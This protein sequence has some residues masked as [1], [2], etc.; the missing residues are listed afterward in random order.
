MLIQEIIKKKRDGGALTPQEITFAVRG[1]ASGGI[2]DYQISA[3]LMA[4]LLRGMQT[5][6]ITAMVEAMTHSGEVVDLSAIPGVK[7]DKHSTGGIGDKV[8]LVLAPLVAALGVKVPMIS[9]RGL[10]HTGGTLDKLE[11]IPGF[12][13]R[14]DLA[15]FKKTVHEVGA[16]LIGQTDNLAPADRKLYALRDVTGTVESPALIASSIL[17]KKF[18][19]GIDGLVMDVKVGSGAFMKNAADAEALAR[20]LISIGK[21]AG[22]P[23]VAVLTDM[24][25]PLGEAVGNALEVEESIAALKGGGPADLRAVTLEL[26]YWM[27]YLAGIEKQRDKAFAAM[28]R[29]LTDGSALK[30]FAAIITAHGGDSSVCEQLTRLPR[31]PHRATVVATTAGFVESIDTEAV[32]VAALILG[33]GRRK[34]E[35]K[36]DP[37]VG[38]MV[39]KK[40]GDAVKSG[41]TLVEIHYRDAA[42]LEE[43]RDRILK[44][45]KLVAKPV[46][47]PAL[48]I[49]TIS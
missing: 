19:A 38:L 8:S 15:K 20:L 31:A 40:I 14:L 44:A 6:E 18:A 1:A 21:Q 12:N 26:G 5:E 25:Q 32:G 27:L 37:A 33:A 4:I 41:E 49:K 17:S 30:K 39:K 36:I 22:K 16:C 23:I 7:I 11:S 13:V 3:L 9:G 29:S 10:G 2:P 28:E 45:Y 48:L 34:A 46:A 47:K 35:D 42:Q 43:A 24:S